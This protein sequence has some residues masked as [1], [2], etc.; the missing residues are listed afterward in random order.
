MNVGKLNIGPTAQFGQ[1][2][3]LQAGQAHR[4]QRAPLDDAL[5]RLSDNVIGAQTQ[6]TEQ[7]TEA[8]KVEIKKDLFISNL[9][10]GKNRAL[11]ELSDEELMDLQHTFR[12]AGRYAQ[13][14]ENA[15]TDFR[16]QLSAYDQTIQDYQD[17]A[18]GKRDLAEGMTADTARTLAES[19]RNARERFLS[20]GI[21]DMEKGASY[22]AHGLVG[23]FA[24][25]NGANRLFGDY[26]NRDDSFWHVDVHADDIYGEIDRVRNAVRDAGD[27][28]GGI[29][30]AI[31]KEL[32]RRGY[33]EDK[34]QIYF[35]KLRE[36]FMPNAEQQMKANSA[37]S[38][39]KYMEDALEKADEE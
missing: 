5:K 39:L 23:A 2:I 16:D 12:L 26:E 14:Y 21:K 3:L 29:L 10:S 28:S 17:M 31:N 13:I 6:R 33:T 38:V 35:D 18:D 1:Q 34:Y 30:N 25:Y 36:N 22:D 37:A 11:E 27:H 8:R 20:D 9:S 7:K 32:E 4:Q 19:A 24:M 15:L